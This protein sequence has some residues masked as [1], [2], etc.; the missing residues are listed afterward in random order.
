MDKDKSV[1]TTGNK[2]NKASKIVEIA[3]LFLTIA[4]TIIEIVEKAKEKE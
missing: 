4:T 2:I 3:G 1:N